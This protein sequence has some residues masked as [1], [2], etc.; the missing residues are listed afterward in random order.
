MFC[1]QEF[2]IK[3]IPVCWVRGVGAFVLVDSHGHGRT[4]DKLLLLGD[5]AQ[6]GANHENDYGR[7]IHYFRSRVEPMRNLNDK[8]K[9]EGGGGWLMSEMQIFR[10]RKFCG[11]FFVNKHSTE[12]H[13]SIDSAHC[14]PWR[15]EHGSINTGGVN[16]SVV[17]RKVRGPAKK[18]ER[19]PFFN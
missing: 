14:F 12:P 19:N 2:P 16:E 4:I 8:R 9:K 11:I 3:S 17:K 7:E 10:K 13:Q 18:L 6:D 15:S 5:K 1:T